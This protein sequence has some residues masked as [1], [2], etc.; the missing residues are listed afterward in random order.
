MILDIH[1]KLQVHC[2]IITENTGG[3]TVSGGYFDRFQDVFSPE[4][5]QS[6]YGAAS[7]P[8]TVSRNRYPFIKYLH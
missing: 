1:A 5:S 7:C 2:I 8:R 3:G 6:L 4:S